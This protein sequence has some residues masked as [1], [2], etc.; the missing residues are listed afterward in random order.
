MQKQGRKN[1]KISV[2]DADMTGFVEKIRN[3]KYE[4]RNTKYE[5]RNTL[6]KNREQRTENR[7][8]RTEN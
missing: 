1:K 5:I 6:I 2:N 4:I 3:T 7:E 8:Q